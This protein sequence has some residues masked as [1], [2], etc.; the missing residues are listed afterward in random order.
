GRRQIARLSDI[1]GQ[2]RAL[3]EV[4]RRELA[5]IPGLVAPAEPDWARSN[6]QSYCVRLP[7]GVDQRHVMQRMLDDGVSSRR[8]IMCA[9]R[10]DSY[11][12]Q[13][14]R[15]PLPE[16]EAAQDRCIIIPLYTQMTESEQAKVVE[17]LRSAILL[18]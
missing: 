1:V 17:S 15:H 11:R 12:D 9:H 2:R 18:D 4:Y 16:S 7:D 3:A 5:D 13:P 14:L 6:W 10:E 8:G